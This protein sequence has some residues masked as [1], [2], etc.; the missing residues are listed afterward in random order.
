MRRFINRRP[1]PQA[2]LLLAALPFL[3]L[4]GIYLAAS[5]A[6]LAENPKDKLLPAPSSFA[7]SM[8]EMA[9]EE[10]KRSGQYL[11]WADTARQPDAPRHRHLGR[12]FASG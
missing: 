5:N 2:G 12:G 7:A 11:F 3:L 10:D 4:I 6:R 9:F 8:K 1:G